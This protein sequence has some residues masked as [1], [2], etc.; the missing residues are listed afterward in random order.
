MGSQINRAV[1]HFRL[2]RLKVKGH[3]RGSSLQGVGFKEECWLSGAGAQ[4]SRA[5]EVE[6]WKQTPEIPVGAKDVT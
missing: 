6:V 3:H 5:D 1:V 2:G 4:A